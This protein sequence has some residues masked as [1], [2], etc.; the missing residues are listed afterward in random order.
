MKKLNKTDEFTIKI[1]EVINEIFDEDSDHFT[2]IKPSELTDFIHALAN[3][4]PTII[5]EKITGET[6]NMLEFN[7]IA[8]RLCFQNMNKK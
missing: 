7:H 6:V 4:V 1:L 3:V 8:N 2:E 5:Y